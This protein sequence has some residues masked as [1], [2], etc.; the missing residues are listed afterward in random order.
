MKMRILFVDDQP[1]ILEGLRRL[2]R[3][4][5][6]EWDMEFA[7]GG[8]E[9]LD[10]MSQ[11]QFDVVV[12]DMRMPG[13]SGAE[14]LARIREQ[15]PDTVRIILSG[16]SDV[17][18]IQRSVGATHQYL[19]KPCSPEMLKTTLDRAR[20]LRNLLA[21]D[22]LRGLVSQ[23]TSLPSLPA[24]YNQLVQELQSPEASIQ[25]VAELIGRDISMTTKLLQL[26]NSS[27]FGLPHRVESPAH[28]ASLLGLNLLRPLVLSVG[29]FTNFEIPDLPGFSL[30]TLVEHSIAVGEAAQLIAADYAPRDK[31][32]Q[33]DA[34]LAG[35]IHDVGQIVLANNVTT[36]YRAVL[37]ASHD[38][39]VPLHIVEQRHLGTDH[40]K[41]GAYLLNLWGLPDAVVEATACHHQPQHCQRDGFTPLTAVYAA[42]ILSNQ[43]EGKA[44][45]RETNVD[46]AYLQRCG[47][48]D[49]LERWREYVR[50]P[51]EKVTTP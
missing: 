38:E 34:L 42:N 36:D 3:G 50:V 49:R 39:Q 15:Y 48:A 27:F 1:R 51:A 6:H 22:S 10:R 26:L 16:Q 7:T 5:R 37:Q 18:S 9:A 11:Q 47:V 2:L 35:L 31:A 12:S 30:D 41:V 21:D 20:T 33:D 44:P 13:M 14:L 23:V 40:S 43:S 4:C 24:N 19:S 29:I 25:R 45:L 46:D 32:L 17:G 8:R 28:A